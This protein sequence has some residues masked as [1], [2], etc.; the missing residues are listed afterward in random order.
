MSP[1][2]L[3]F[4]LCECVPR[5]PDAA[6]SLL[7]YRPSSFLVAVQLKVILLERTCCTH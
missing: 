4:P 3:V 6:I 5:L 1:F 7:L 2:P